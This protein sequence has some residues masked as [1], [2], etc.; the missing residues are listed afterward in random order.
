MSRLKK[1]LVA[2]GVTLLLVVAYL[3]FWPVP[4]DP[5]AWT[6]PEAPRLEGVYAKNDLLS[7]VETFEVP[8][9]GPED[10]DVDDQGRIYAGLK[11]GRVVRMKSDGTGLEVFAD[12]G[13]R[14]LGMD[15]DGA[16]N[17][18]VADSEKGLLSITPD[19]S[20]TAL[21]SE[22]GGVRF[23]LTDDV[24]VAPDGV[25]YFSDASS[26]WSVGEIRNDVLEH[27][28]H[29]RLLAYDPRSK[30]TR[31]V[32]DQLYFA[33]GVAVSRDGSFVLVSETTAYRIKRHWLTGE[34]AG[35]TETLIDNL[36]GMP[37]GVSTGSEGRFW[38]ALFAPR[39]PT[40][41]ALLP[42]PWLR[43]VIYRLPAF[44]QPD[45]AREGFVL[46]LDASG[47]VVHNLQDHAPDCFAPV[48]SVEEHGG[49]IYFG[50]L[51]RWAIARMPTPAIA[52]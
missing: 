7:A 15:F 38:V 29:G 37:D 47:T 49:H 4:I 23:G 18:I 25:I 46:A 31:L 6:P 27:R 5:A 16:G 48:T 35:Q 1:G 50:S 21:T 14:P 40:L 43:K 34:R 36:P 39:M 24:A 26:R 42:R 9:E 32:L 10:V 28:P 30:E 17:L 8:G 52:R 22:Q 2:L 44:M 45:P 3:L 33:N 41:D 13:G 12:T 11:D 20:V 19:G 51:A